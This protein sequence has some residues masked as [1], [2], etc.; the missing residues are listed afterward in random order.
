M[1]M[2]NE[3]IRICRTQCTHVI[4]IDPHDLLTPSCKALEK[5]YKPNNAQSLHL[6][7]IIWQR[8][9]LFVSSH[10]RLAAKYMIALSTM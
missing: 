2:F 8:C 9:I 4:H 7:P 6:D 5:P 1:R 10:S 3:I